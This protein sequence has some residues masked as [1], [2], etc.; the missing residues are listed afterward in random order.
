MSGQRWLAVAG[1]LGALA[2]GAGAFGAHGLRAWL[3]DIDPQ[4]AAGRLDNW[5]TAAHYQLIHAAAMAVAAL[6]A[7]SSYWGHAACALYATGVV[8]FSGCLYLYVLTTDRLWAL[9]V[10]IGGSAWIAG[11]LCLAAAGLSGVLARKT[12][13]PF[14]VGT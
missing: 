14:D 10:P 4:S 6:V 2:V 8:L 12:E 7:R 1:L 9:P 5:N 13:N 11:W 3:A